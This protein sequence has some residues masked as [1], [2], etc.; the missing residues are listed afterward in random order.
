MAA[1]HQLCPD[2]GKDNLQI[3]DS[4]STYCHTADCVGYTPADRVKTNTDVAAVPKAATQQS[5]KTINNILSTADYKAVESRGITSKTAKTYGVVH[6]SKGNT[7]F[8]YYNPEDSVVPIACKTRYPDKR[9]QVSGDWKQAGLFGQQLFSK[10][11]RYVTITEGEFDALAAYQMSGSK[12]PV[13]SIRNGAGGAYKDCKEHYEW[14]DSFENIII[15]FD[16]DEPGRKAAKEVADLFGGKSKVVKHVKGCKDACD[17]LAQGK[18]KEFSDVFWR[19]EKYVPDGIVNGDTLW[20]EVNSPVEASPYQFPFESLNDKTFGIRE[21]EILTIGAGSGVGKTHFVKELVYQGLQ[22]TEGN[23]GLLCLEEG[24]PA[25]AKALVSLAAGKPLH[26]PTTES[27][28]TERRN[29]FDKTLGTGRFY[30]FNHFGSVAVE[31]ILSR[32]KYMVKALDCTTVLLDHLSIVVSA[33]EETDE[34]KAIDELMTKLRMLTEETNVRMIVVT[35][36]N[37]PGSGKPHEEGGQT[38]LVQLRGSGS[39][40]HL[41]DTVIG[42]ERNAQADDAYERNLTTPRVLKNRFAGLTGACNRIY[43]DPETGR[44]AEEIEEAL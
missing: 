11:G 22:A 13:V 9:F 20:E 40:A 23:I 14:L 33:Q 30:L 32:I 41:S 10:G 15:C 19:A 39:I 8:G 16:D 27:T 24:N 1:T 25:T 29:A 37:R 43:Y 17:Y 5:F 31:S 3:N 7:Y 36:L 35:H 34:R 2:C 38:S 26:L 21:G 42:L 12:Y 18:V 6:Q 4:G 44:M 28:E